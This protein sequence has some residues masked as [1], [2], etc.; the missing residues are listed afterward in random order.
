MIEKVQFIVFVTKT[1]FVDFWGAFT[2]TF[3]LTS[4]WP[5]LN[6]KFQGRDAWTSRSDLARDFENFVDL[7]PIWSKIWIFIGP[8][9]VRD[10]DFFLKFSIKSKAWTLQVGLQA[11]PRFRNLSVWSVD[12]CFW[13][14]FYK[15][16]VR[17][18]LFIADEIKSESFGF[19]T[20][21]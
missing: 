6:L 17:L 11:G 13:A 2:E 4:K 10:L 8:D 19:L 14:E 16:W 7:G 15:T 12:P 5:E 1:F 9:P 18:G 21:W 3:N 20:K